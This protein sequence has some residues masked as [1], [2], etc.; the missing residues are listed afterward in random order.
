MVFYNEAL[1]KILDEEH[2][3]DIMEFINKPAFVND[4]LPTPMSLITAAKNRYSDYV[5]SQVYRLHYEKEEGKVSA[6]GAKKK[7]AVAVEPAIDNS[8]KITFRRNEIFFNGRKSVML[9]L[10]EVKE[11]DGV[12]QQ[13][14]VGQVVS[15]SCSVLSNDLAQPFES[16]EYIS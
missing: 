4:E 8:K 10:R 5:L 6:R 2:E 14:Q 7:K 9:N 12:N 13:M 1:M 16:I 11:M 3:E 15:Q